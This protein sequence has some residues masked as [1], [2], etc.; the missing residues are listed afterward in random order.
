MTARTTPT[1][2][3]S[4]SPEEANAQ[5]LT[6]LNKISEVQGYTLRSFQTWKKRYDDFP[7][8]K[9]TLVAVNQQWKYLYCVREVIQW[10]ELAAFLGRIEDRTT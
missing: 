10:M 9:A 4:L 2:I 8:P 5:Q 7:K 3:P 6:T 1:H